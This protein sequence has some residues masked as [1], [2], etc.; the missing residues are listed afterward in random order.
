LQRVLV[1]HG[2][3]IY[4]FDESEITE[5]FDDQMAGPALP[6]TM[7]SSGSLKSPAP[8]DAERWA[9]NMTIIE[10]T[11]YWP[12]TAH[13]YLRNFDSKSCD[14]LLEF[15]A[16]GGPYEVSNCEGDFSRRTNI[17]SAES[18]PCCNSIEASINQKC[19]PLIH[20]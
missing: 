15:E 11:N 19:R 1:R 16:D 10:I 6:L 9:L 5:L 18:F 4:Q 12:N 3:L 17:L 8:A 20:P 14:L 2:A 7:A 13:C